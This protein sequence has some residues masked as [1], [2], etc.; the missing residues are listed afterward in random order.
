MKDIRKDFNIVW[1]VLCWNE[2]PI[3]PFIIDYWKL[4]ARKVIVFDNGST[5]GTLEY[6]ST[7]DW[8]EVRPYPIKTNNTI[9]DEI[10]KQIKNE[11]WKEQKDKNVD[12]VIVSDLDEI[13][14]AKDLYEN[15]K[16]IKERNAA[17]IKPCGYDFISLQFP[18]HG[19]LLLH[20]QIKTCYR[21]GDEKPKNL[22]YGWSTWDKSIIFNPDLV[23]EINY[24]PG[25]HA[26][27]PILKNNSIYGTSE[28]LFLFHF[29][30]LSPE[31]LIMKRFATAG[32]L[33]QTNLQ[34]GYGIE[35]RYN[36]E[37]IINQFN[38]RWRICNGFTV[39]KIL[40]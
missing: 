23:E 32:R 15:L 37:Q 24:S 31:Y 12:F 10:H 5:D 7:F 9:N 36:R 20:E 4:I 1:Y 29:K 33:S 11:C 34:M 3:L 22:K 19:D 39:D 25:G 28:S 30:Y 8:I 21:I 14:W 2:M 40:K 35:Y 38:E 6:L 18:I 16:Y 13:I 17:V 27:N 26:C